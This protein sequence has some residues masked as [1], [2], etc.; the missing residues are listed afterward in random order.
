[1]TNVFLTGAS[2]F[3]GRNLLKRF[4][5]ESDDKFFVLLRNSARSQGYRQQLEDY[6]QQGRVEFVNGDIT[7]PSCGVDIQTQRRLDTLI[8]EVWHSAASTEFD[9]SRRA[10]IELLNLVG[11]GN[12]LQLLKHNKRLDDFFYVSTA[13][14]AGTSTTPVPEGN[15]TPPGFKNPYEQTKLACEKILR[16][17]DVPLTIVR[18]SILIGDSVTLDPDGETRMIYGYC[19]SFFLPLVRAFK[20]QKEYWQW[21]DYSKE[22]FDTQG[23]RINA[24][25]RTTLNTITMDDTTRVFDAIRH[26]PYHHGMTYNVVNPQ[27]VKMEWLMDTMERC[28]KIRNM[29]LDP[30]LT[31][32]GMHPRSFEGTAWRVQE[33]YFP[34][35][36]VLEPGWE[37]ENVKAVV[38]DSQRVIMTSE[39]FYNLMQRFFS[40]LQEKRYA[41][42]HA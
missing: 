16:L 33:R 11:T 32:E 6:V 20:G 35:F 3:L 10:E 1:M 8:Q 12:L 31:N 15:F 2:G 34:Y 22:S 21:H 17:S 13:Y 14:V 18:P 24:D 29:K 42:A 41:V 38:P 9:E 7:Q 30:H 37:R 27:P 4:L 36:H 19:T 26:D 5:Q 39:L 25:P 40:G 23:A 28:L